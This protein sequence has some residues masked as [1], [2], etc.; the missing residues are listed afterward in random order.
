MT[1]KA[2]FCECTETFWIEI[3]K[4]LENKHDWQPCYWTA[5][6]NQDLVKKY[7]PQIIFHDFFK[8]IRGIPAPELSDMKSAVIGEDILRKLAICESMVLK[9]MDR[10]DPED[11]FLYHERIRLY[12]NYLMYWKTVIDKF[13]PDVVVF[14]TPPHVAF[15]FVLYSLCCLYKIK[16]IM[17]YSTTMEGLVFP[18]N[19]FETDYPV[20]V[21][22]NK[23]LKQNHTDI[24]L[25]KKAKAHLDRLK[26]SYHENLAALPE[27]TKGNL[28]GFVLEK[29]QLKLLDRFSI[30][31]ITKRFVFWLKYIIL[32]VL[33]FKRPGRRNYQKRRGMKIEESSWTDFQY[34]WYKYKANK[35]KANLSIYY[36]KLALRLDCTEPYIYVALHYQPE[37]STSPMGGFFVHQ[38]LM[39]DMLSKI[40]PDGWKIIVKENL[41]QNQ[42]LSHGERDRTKDFYDDL[43][44]ISNV[45]L[46]PI[47]TP[48]W[49]LIDNAKA[50][51][52]V[53]GTTGWEAVVRGK[54]V[55]NFGHSWYKG[56][57]GVFYTPTQDECSKVI[58]KILNGY[59]VN[60]NKVKLFLYSLEKIGFIAFGDTNFKKFSGISTQ[61]NIK[62]LTEKINKQFSVDLV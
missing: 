54:P 9:M 6:G 58:E 44:T 24:S 53:T 42:S 52:T 34:R 2:I 22:Y 23:L 45:Q 59:H 31:I 39:V 17:L 43:V 30:A 57:E 7:F 36:E 8:A 3:A 37:L 47:S 18:M 19:R 12:H 10:M 48:Q 32:L 40:V 26:G 11:C 21:L 25:S 13:R 38:L 16:T 29:K 60:S 61:E 62:I 35:K 28:P 14:H 20:E 4:R 49:D 55:F 50:V 27:D 51:A 5:S 33:S 15:N 56:C 41:F 46:V 1:V